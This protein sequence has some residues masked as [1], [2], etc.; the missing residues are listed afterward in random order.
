MPD[1]CT[2][3]IFG[4][5]FQHLPDWRIVPDKSYSLNFDSGMFRFEE[6]YADAKSRISMGLR[7]ECSDMSSEEFLQMFGENIEKEYHK[8]IKGKKQRFELLHNEIVHNA[9][10]V[11]MRYVAT[12]YG[13]SQALFSAG[14]KL[15]RLCVSNMG[16]YCE[17]THRIVVCS[18]V[19]T[20]QYMEENREVLES[21]LMSIRTHDVYSP[22]AEQA[23]M[24]KRAQIRYDA[25][26]PKKPFSEMLERFSKKKD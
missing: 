25:A 16:F 26:H 14:K 10:G 17:K 2:I 11:P 3:D 21:L 1:T 15:Q 4:I 5:T 22:E 23:R 19:T 13:A 20:P 7:W 12:Q 18:L 9:D 8:K 6:N 24:E